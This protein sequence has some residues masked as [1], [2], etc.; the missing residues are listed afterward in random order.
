MKKHSMARAVQLAFV[1]MSMLGSSA[2][3]AA[4]DKDLAEIRA[5]IKEMRASYEAR[6]QALEQRLQEAQQKN[7]KLEQTVA[8]NVVATEAANKAAVAATAAA[9]AQAATSPAATSAAAAKPGAKGASGNLFNPAISMVLVGNYARTSQDP[10]AY[11]L[12]GFVP[13]GAEGVGPLKRGFGL[14]ESEITLSAAVDP[15]FS[16]QMT[17]AL[18]GE[19]A[20]E[21]E[22]AFIQAQNLGNGMNLKFGRFLSALGYQNSQHSHAWDFADVPLAYSAL[23]GG[24]TRTN[25]LQFKW[26][27]PTST[28]LQF[29]AEL[30]NGSGF[31]GTDSNRNGVG[32]TLLFAQLGDDIGSNGSWRLGLSH[33][34][35]RARDRTWEDVDAA[36]VASTNSFSGR[37][38]ATILD[39]VFKWSMPGK[40]SFK[41]QGEYIRR[42]ESGDL[43]SNAS[44]GE[45]MLTSAYHSRQSGWYLQSVLQ[46]HP[47]WRVG[48]RHD[49][50]K[51][52]TTDIG[53]VQDGRVA[54]ENF[55]LLANY[56]PRRT[57]M[58]LDWNRSEF[59]RIRLQYSRDQSR[60]GAS[61]NQLYLQY[62]MSLGA[63]GA[64][65]F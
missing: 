22:E 18:D 19:E 64:H 34:R 20:A 40:R 37:S 17:F 7:A 10:E 12:Q 25:G 63:H 35:T 65:S 42:T 59:S 38:R 45:D 44:L 41:L 15:H 60:P 11:R 29:G 48:L 47:E 8:Q 3:L 5:Q 9:G 58:M 62:I 16:G 32:S 4:D 51:S 43:T 55:P 21:V 6:L 57:S 36:D 53:F 50:V 31:P 1:S 39:G 27:A 49:R 13:S 33:L 56:N 26:L 61:D 24:Q 14:G 30:G 52:G 2:V 23:L 54:A 28:F 46:F